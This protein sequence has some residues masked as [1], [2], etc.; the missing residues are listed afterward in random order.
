MY[1]IGILLCQMCHNEYPRIDRRQEQI[2]NAKKKYSIL[3]PLLTQTLH[4]HPTERPEA[5]M[6]GQQLLS[7]IENDRYYPIS[8]RILPEKDI[9][10]L[11]YHSM[12]KQMNSK[13]N[14]LLI[15]LEKTQK[16]LTIEEKR[17][18]EEAGKVDLI[19]NEK[20]RFYEDW[21]Q[22]KRN[23][24]RVMQEK[25]DLFSQFT[26]L[27]QENIHLIDQLKFCSTEISSLQEKMKELNGNKVSSELT[28]K[29]QIQEI[30]SF[31][32]KEK[33][34][35]IEMKVSNEKYEKL[36]E[37]LTLTQKQLAMQVDYSKDLENRLEQIL[38]RWKEEKE[39]SN[40]EKTKNISL[41]AAYS[42][43]IHQRDELQLEYSR[44]DRKLRQ[45]EGLPLPV[46][47][48]IST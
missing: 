5:E 36:N 1:L 22:E 45:Y 15:N 23:Y 4:F 37:K 47:H 26:N 12:T 3:S 43:L 29:Q 39:I 44:C 9:G 13:Y 17:W 25:S 14:E 42:Q 6:I 30:Q 35:S 28:I 34:H 38:T 48:V 16:L 10:I 18:K 21:Q 31:K 32:E 8:R 40:Q 24:E 11:G 7:I 20:N 46:S 41:N 2:D 27:Q 19:E 33:N